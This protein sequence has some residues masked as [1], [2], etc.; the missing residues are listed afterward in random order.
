MSSPLIE[1]QHLKKY[2][3]IRRGFIK[4]TVGQVR[5][6]DDVSFTINKGEVFGL[7]GES[8][9]GKSTT[10]LTLLRAYAPTAGSV[11]FN[12]QRSGATYELG[13]MTER[14]LVPLRKELQ[15]VF[16]D[17]YSSLNSRMT[18]REVIGEPMVIHGIRDPKKIDEKV[19]Y[20]LE[21]VGM[22]AEHMKRY[23]HAFS[24]GQR[25]RIAIARA[26]SID[27][28][29]VVCD[30]SVSALDVSVQAQ[31]LNLLRQLQ[32]EFDLTYLFIAHDLSVIKHISDRVGVMYAGRLVEVADTEELFLFPQHPYTES[33]LSAV[34][35][36]DPD[37]KS[38]RI[39][40]TGEIPNPANPPSGCY[41]HPRCP[42]AQEKCS[43][44]TPALRP[45]G[46]HDSSRLAAC[47]FAEELD[48]AGVTEVPG[49]V[50]DQ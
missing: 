36:P 17:P 42:Y 8:G 30:E 29:F 34:P 10:A 33:L 12:D 35:Q 43:V 49:A 21:S 3:P 24:G 15:V 26:L 9:S 2:F 23:P 19:L 5:A 25:Q 37:A 28:Q 27:P 11:R 14:Q 16:Q 7:V 40:L 4:R 6:V 22:R 46:A 39:V 44:E 38:D 18:V 45:V 31:I 20:L 1:V 32:E 13:D 50:A 48:L 41:F 47:H